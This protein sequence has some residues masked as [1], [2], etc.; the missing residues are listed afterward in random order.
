MSASEKLSRWDRFVR[1]LAVVLDFALGC[2]HRHMSRVFTLDGRTY[3]VCCDC[4]KDFDYSLQ[5]MSIMH[6]RGLRPRLRYL[7]TRHT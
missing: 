7:R 6:R 2:H 4:G 5:K 1:P 3:K